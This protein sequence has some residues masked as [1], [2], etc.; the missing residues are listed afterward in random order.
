MYL[1]IIIA[2]S[3]LTGIV[4][5]IIEK[6]GLSVN[7]HNSIVRN[8]SIPNKI[9]RVRKKINT[10][11]IPV[12]KPDSDLSNT[13]EVLDVS[14]KSGVETNDSVP[15]IYHSEPVFLGIVDDEII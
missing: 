4:T 9:V 5:T 11:S 10:V 2:F 14:D 6:K 3:I 12:V 13:I 8:V 15:K 1:T 7:T